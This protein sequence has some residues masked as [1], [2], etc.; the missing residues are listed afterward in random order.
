MKK[1]RVKPFVTLFL[2]MVLAAV[3]AGQ[4]PAV[5]GDIGE[6]FKNFKLFKEHELLKKF[7]GSMDLEQPIAILHVPV[8][9]IGMPPPWRD[10]DLV[11][12]AYIWFFDS[13]GA[14]VGYTMESTSFP[15]AFQTGSCLK[16]VTVRCKEVYGMVTES[17]SIQLGV[18][19]KKGDDVMVLGR[20]A[21][22]KDSA[23]FFV[24]S[25]TPATAPKCHD[26]DLSCGP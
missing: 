24:L 23:Q 7:G 21:K 13:N 16:E 15:G 11:V 2:A 9:V 6:L 20:A 4:R 22:E 3:F 8:K 14:S 25:F 5:A 26:G 17:F 10:A 19:A 18:I 1:T 12:W